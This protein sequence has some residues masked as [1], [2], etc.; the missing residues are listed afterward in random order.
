MAYLRNSYKH[1]ELVV[2]KRVKGKPRTQILA[3]FDSKKEIEEFLES[4]KVSSFKRRH[5]LK[6]LNQEFL[7]SRAG[8]IF[9]DIEGPEPYEHKIEGRRINTTRPSMVKRLAT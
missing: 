9:R 2:S 1:I 6:S 7:L 3:R 5:G 8:E 4:N